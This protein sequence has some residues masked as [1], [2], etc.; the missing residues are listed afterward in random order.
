MNQSFLDLYFQ[1]TA[2]HY[3]AQ[4]T[5]QTPLWSSCFTF[6][7]TEI[8]RIITMP[9]SIFKLYVLFCE[10]S[11]TFLQFLVLETV[12]CIYSFKETN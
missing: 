9:S 10:K 11:Y 7:V 3:V 2:A 8:P 1:D 5:L 4:A 12:I 6:P